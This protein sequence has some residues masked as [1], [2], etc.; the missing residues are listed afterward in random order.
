[1]EINYDTIM[2]YLTP[3]NEQ[4]IG[5]NTLNLPVNRLCKKNIISDLNFL[6]VDLTSVLKSTG[7]FYRLGVTTNIEEKNKL[8]NVSFFTSVLTILDNKF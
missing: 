6:N 4:D 7:N 3:D 1:M 8:I 5:E 2:K